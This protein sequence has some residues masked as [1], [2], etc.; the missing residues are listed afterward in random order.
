MRI[1][2]DLIQLPA[3][4]VTLVHDLAHSVGPRSDGGRKVTQDEALQIAQDAAELAQAILRLLAAR[5]ASGE[6]V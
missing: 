3:A 2:S 4:I 6:Q 5:K 1:D